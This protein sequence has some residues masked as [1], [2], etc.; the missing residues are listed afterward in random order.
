MAE[1]M[2][3]VLGE[4][5]GITLS[6]ASSSLM[7]SSAPSYSCLGARQLQHSCIENVEMNSL[8]GSLDTELVSLYL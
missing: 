7:F 2:E 8:L 1:E 6:L 4:E 3:I 5:S